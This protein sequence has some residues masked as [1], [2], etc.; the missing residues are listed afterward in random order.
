MVSAFIEDTG[1][2]RDALPTVE[3]FVDLLVSLELLEFFIRVEV[4]VLV[5]KS[6]YVTEMDQIGLHMV[7]ERPGV[8][9][10]CDRPVDGVLHMTCLEMRVVFSHLP[11]LFQSNAVVLDTY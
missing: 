9:I 5:I 6:D 4:W 8:D 10:R 3:D 1:T 2:V 7:H 11:D